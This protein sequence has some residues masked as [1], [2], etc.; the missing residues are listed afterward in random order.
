MYMFA[1]LFLGSK[2]FLATDKVIHESGSDAE[3]TTQI[4]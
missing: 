3:R 4:Y 2:D 1:F